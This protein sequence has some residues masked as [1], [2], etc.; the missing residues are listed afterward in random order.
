[1]R[2]GGVERMSRFVGGVEMRWRSSEG[3]RIWYVDVG[4][5]GAG[6]V[7]KRGQIVLAVGVVGIE[8]CLKRV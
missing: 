2:K 6:Y 5:S 3:V 8:T 4:T 7:R 1:M